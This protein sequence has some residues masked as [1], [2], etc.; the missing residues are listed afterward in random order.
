MSITGNKSRHCNKRGTE[1]KTHLTSYTGHWRHTGKSVQWE[2][3]PSARSHGFWTWLFYETTTQTSYLI[4]GRF[5]FFIR[6]LET[7]E[8]VIVTYAL[9]HKQP[10]PTLVKWNRTECAKKIWDAGCKK[11]LKNIR[12][13]GQKQR[14]PIGTPTLPLRAQRP[15]SPLVP[16]P[17]SQPRLLL[18]SWEWALDAP[19]D[20][21]VAHFWETPQAGSSQWLSRG[22]TR[23]L[24]LRGWA[25][26]RLLSSNI[27][28]DMCSSP[29]APP[30]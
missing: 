15:A 26:G 13:N 9:G 10:K 27:R 18:P 12:K 29:S 3:Q 30:P 7:A 11:R 25:R 22:P 6:K 21:R 16:Q 4:S 8:P 14:S 1:E 24:E 17:H 20:F 28:R 2:K 5:N 23:A 19:Q